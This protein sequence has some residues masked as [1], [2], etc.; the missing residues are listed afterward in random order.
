MFDYI[1]KAKYLFVVFQFPASLPPV[2]AQN[3]AQSI[4]DI[5]FGNKKK[6]NRLYVE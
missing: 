3:S 1:S 2:S 5:L 4:E 6:E